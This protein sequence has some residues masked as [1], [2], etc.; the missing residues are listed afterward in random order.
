MKVTV[1]ISTKGIQ[2]VL[3]NGTLMDATDKE[4]GKQ[5]KDRL[6]KEIEDDHLVEPE[7][8]KN[9]TEAQV[10]KWSLK[11][12]NENI[13]LYPADSLLGEFIQA[14]IDEKGGSTDEKPSKA[15]ATKAAKP[16]REAKPK[17]TLE[18]CEKVQAQATKKFVG[19]IVD[20]SAFGSGEM[21]TGRAASVWIDKRVPAVFVKIIL[22]GGKIKNKRPD[23]PDLT[24]NEEATEAYHAEIAAKEA[25]KAEAAAAKKAAAKEKAEAKKAAAAAKKAE[26]KEKAEAKK[27]AAAKKA[28][29]K[30][31]AAAAKK[32]EAKKAAAVAA[33][34]KKA[35][36][37]S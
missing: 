28:E 4:N 26:A 11:K 34:A 33:A 21:C 20:F 1:F 24:I 15:K 14:Q 10:S 36:A 32:A 7:F 16:K 18:E 13:E 35:E 12:L 2:A 22:E 6:T 27:A 5:F 25:A 30:K 3:E 8:T 37:K 23:A 29:A 19:N 17:P 9:I 31:A